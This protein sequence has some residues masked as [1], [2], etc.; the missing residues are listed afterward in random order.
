MTTYALEGAVFNGGRL[1]WLRTSC[2]WWTPPRSVTGWR[3]PWKARRRGGGSGLH[4]AGC[5][6][7]GYVRPWGHSGHHPWYGP[8]PYRPCGAGV[9]RLSGDGS[10][11]GHAAGCRVRH[12]GPAGRRRLSV[13]DILMQMQAD[14]L[15]IPVDRPTMVETTAFGAASLADWPAA[16]GGI[17]RSW[18]LCGAASGCSCPSGPRQ[19]ATMSTA[20]GKKAVS[21]ACHWAE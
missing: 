11:A 10:D 14:L 9:H 21:R 4:R 2:S 6:L 15:R 1:Q 17:R 13:S 18:R 12:H 19:T 7:L 3:N 5:A 20:C 8:G 16:C